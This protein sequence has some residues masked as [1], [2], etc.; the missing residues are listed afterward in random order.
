MQIQRKE[1]NK[2]GIFYLNNDDNS[3]QLAELIYTMISPTRMVIEHT[4]VNKAVQGKHLGSDLVKA[5]VEYARG[6]QIKILPNCPFAKEIFRRHPELDDV[7]V[8]SV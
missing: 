1:I 8:H 5:A 6:R 4:E 3:R 7:L 2:Q